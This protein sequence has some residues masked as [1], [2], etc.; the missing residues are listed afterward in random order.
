MS[1]PAVFVLALVSLF[2]CKKSVPP[3]AVDPDAGVKQDD[4]KRL[5][6]GA[7]PAMEKCYVDALA[8]APG[9]SGKVTLVFAVNK[10]GRVDTSRTGMANAGDPGFARCVLD[11]LV[12]IEF[13]K[14]GVVTDV[15]FPLDLAKHIDPAVLASASAAGSAALAAASA[16]AAQGAG[17]TAPSAGASGSAAASAGAPSVGA[18]A[19]PSASAAPSGKTK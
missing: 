7:R 2:G 9:L 4:V 12:K 13:P 19:K 16:S 5:L 6:K 1:R 8:R 10:D 11:Q 15:E 14:P 3:A 18:S 17:S